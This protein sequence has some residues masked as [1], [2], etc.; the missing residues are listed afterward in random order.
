[1]FLWLRP[2]AKERVGFHPEELAP[3]RSAVQHVVRCNWRGTSSAWSATQVPAWDMSWFRTYRFSYQ[4]RRVLEHWPSRSSAPARERSSTSETPSRKTSAP[5]SFSS[6][7][8]LSLMSVVQCSH[9]A[10]RACKRIFW[11]KSSTR[12]LPYGT[13]YLLRHYLRQRLTTS[14]CDSSTPTGTVASQVRCWRCAPP[15]HPILRRPIPGHMEAVRC[16]LS[17]FDW[18]SSTRASAG[19]KPASQ[20]AFRWSPASSTTQRAL[21]AHSQ[22]ATHTSG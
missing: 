16:V 12:A 21:A 22:S 11:P 7:S 8:M 2:S 3:N 15:D 9:H 1:M 20:H 17:H 5:G 13:S 10:R 6:S 14:L 4:T 18:L 19:A